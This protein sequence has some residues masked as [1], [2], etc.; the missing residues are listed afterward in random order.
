MRNPF[1]RRKPSEAHGEPDPAMQTF[2][3]SGRIP[4]P[5]TAEIL[6]EADRIAARR[7]RENSDTTSESF[8][9]G[10]SHPDIPFIK[11]GTIPNV[12]FSEGVYI[13]N[14]CGILRTTPPRPIDPTE[15]NEGICLTCGFPERY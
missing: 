10:V 1:K 8:I 12:T 5:R 15:A 11:N 7:E 4:N 6:M 9:V 3:A 2:L 14:G 13:C